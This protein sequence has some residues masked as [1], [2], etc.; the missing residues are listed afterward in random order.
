VVAMLDTQ[1]SASATAFAIGIE[2]NPI[3]VRLLLISTATKDDRS[4]S[5]RAVVQFRP[6]SGELAVNS[7]RVTS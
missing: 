2:T 4:T 7:W 3:D 1:A 6:D 5:I